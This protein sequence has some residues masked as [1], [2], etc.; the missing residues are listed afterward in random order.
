MRLLSRARRERGARRPPGRHPEHWHELHRPDARARPARRRTP[1]ARRCCGRRRRPRRPAAGRDPAATRGASTR[2]ASST[3]G[4][5]SGSPRATS[6][7]HLGVDDAAAELSDLAAGTLEAALAIARAQVGEAAPPLPARR[8]RDGQVRRPRAQLRHRRRRDLRGRARRRRRRAARAMRA[9]TQLAVDADADLLRPH[10]RG[11]DLAGRR[12]PAARG[13]VRPAGAHP[14]QP[15]RLLRALG[16]DLGVPGAAQGAAGRRRPR[17]RARVRRADPPDG[18]DGRRARRLRRGRPGDAPPGGR[19]HPRRRGRAAAQARLRRAAR[20]RV[21]RPAAAARARP[22]RRGGPA[23]DHAERAGR[24]H[25]AAGTSAARTARALHEAYAFLRTLEHRIQLFQLRRTHVVPEDEAVA[26][27]AR[28]LARA[29]PRTRSRELDKQWQHHRREV[30]RLHEKLFYRP[31]LV[32]GRPAPRRRGPADPRGGRGPAGRARLR[33]PDG[34][35]APPR[36][37]HRRGHAGPRRSSARCCRRCSTGSPTRPTRTPGCSASAGS[38][39]RSGTTP[40][41]LRL[42]RDEGEV[43]ERLAQVLATSRYA[44]DLLEREPEG[45]RML[46]DDERLAPLGRDAVQTE[47]TSAA[48]APRRP[49]GGRRSRS[50]RSAAASCSGSRRRPAAAVRRRR[51]RRRAHRRHRR[52]P[53]GDAATR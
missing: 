4:C 26:A 42:L 13:Q 18:V 39:R 24:A 52:H 22:R 5:C 36:G 45:V 48:A 47:M 30:R 14:R 6:T 8:D 16:Q 10:R 53:R 19:P 9:A 40:W 29:T 7:H 2:C 17:A 37:A 15:P 27:P 28:P 43:A 51:G 12:H 3:A 34:G 20:R 33:R 31:L 44:T 25:R 32:R 46:G 11:H 41:Y 50:A 1:C 23:A 21:R 38:A 49:R 35:A